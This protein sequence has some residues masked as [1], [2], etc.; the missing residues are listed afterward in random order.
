MKKKISLIAQA[1][2]AMLLISRPAAAQVCPAP[3]SKIAVVYFNGIDTNQLDY[4]TNKV[5]LAQ[6]FGMS[7][8]DR[9]GGVHDVRYPSFHNPTETRLNDVREAFAQ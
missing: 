7:Y 8:T 4:A 5:K 3:L 2:M 1:F 9:A 6:E